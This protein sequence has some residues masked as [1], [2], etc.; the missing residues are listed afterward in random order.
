VVKDKKIESL[1]KSSVKLTLTIDKKAVKTEYDELMKKYTQSAQ[2]K[3]FRKGKV[4]P[5]VLEKKFGESIRAEASM[6]SIEN[7]LKGVFEEIDEKPLPYHS[8]ELQDDIEFDLEKDLKFTVVYDVFP[9]IKLGKYK[10]LEIESPDVSITK[11]DQERELKAVQEQNAM[12]VDKKE[13]AVAEGDITTVDYEELDEEGNPIEG[14]KREGFVFTVG[15]GYNLYKLDEDIIGMNR[16]E[17][18]E[19]SKE[20]PE[21]YEIAELKGKKVKLKVKVT[22]IKEK[23]MPELDDELAQDI[24]EKYKTLDDLKKDIKKKLKE[25]SQQK[26]REKNIAALMEQVIENSPIDLPQSMIEVEQEGS[27]QNFVQQFRAQE[28]EVIQLLAEQGKTKEQL[29][30]EWL[31]STEKKIKNRLLMS[32][33]IEEEKI[34]ITD[35]EI[36]EEIKRQAELGGVPLEDL[37]KRYEDQRMKEYLRSDLADKKLFDTL[38]EETTVEKGKK[39]KFL[40]LMQDKQ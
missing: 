24:S 10:G 30:E 31:P 7:S 4:P 22:A 21:D 35:K 36:E 34:E 27:W 40:D 28:Q 11:E 33:I 2:I 18:K 19:I 14:T 39:V 13:G 38:L 26:I 5:A 37:Q 23:D 15:T 6:N 25:A 16:D 32:K 1:E 29:L 9:E 8:P 12:V 17:E 20:Y 3:G